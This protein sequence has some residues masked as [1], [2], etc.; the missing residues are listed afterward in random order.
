[1]FLKPMKI[2]VGT[3]VFHLAERDNPGIVLED[4]HPDEYHDYSVFWMPNKYHDLYVGKHNKRNL[5]IYE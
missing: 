3:F 5:R 1:M 4:I 2:K